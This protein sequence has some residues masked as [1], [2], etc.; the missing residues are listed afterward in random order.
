MTKS[1][2]R[3]DIECELVAKSMSEFKRII[4]E[5]KYQFSDLIKDI[6]SYLVLNEYVTNI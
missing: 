2:G 4:H 3:S 1:L 6:D 5:M